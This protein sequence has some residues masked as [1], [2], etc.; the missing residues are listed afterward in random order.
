MP[1]GTAITEI[2]KPDGLAASTD[3]WVRL[4]QE[5]IPSSA[6][7]A[8]LNDLYQMMA[9]AQSGK[10]AWEYVYESCPYVVIVD[11]VVRITLPFFVWPSAIGLPYTLSA[12]LGTISDAVA[13][14][15]FRS[16]DMVF[17]HAADVDCEA[18][19][20]GEFVPQMPIFRDDGSTI[21]DVEP[22]VTGSIVSYPES[23][24]T[25]LR[26]DGKAFGFRH[27]LV[28][29]ITKAATDETA[30]DQASQT[31]EIETPESAITVAWTDENGETQTD[32][33]DI[34]IPGCVTD[35]LATCPD[36]ELKGDPHRPENE[37]LFVV[38][39]S[40]CNGEELL[41]RWETQK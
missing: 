13:Y 33:M 32:I 37:D 2:V 24:T 8:D 39:C 40:N 41:A 3:I 15:E 21:D 29:E 23:V 11:G 10:S 14:E 4:T 9:A 36:G 25:V 20:V 6:D 16:F 18:I 19:F 31:Y 30:E 27:E 34:K 26:A 7:E 1:T 17:D 35:L 28:I 5:A 12:T 38:Y 22:T